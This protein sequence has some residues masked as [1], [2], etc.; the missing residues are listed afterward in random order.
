MVQPKFRNQ[1]IGS[2]FSAAVI[3]RN[4]GSLFRKNFNNRLAK[5]GCSAGY[6]NYFVF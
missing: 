5:T 1:R 3:Y 2:L 4:V 6:K